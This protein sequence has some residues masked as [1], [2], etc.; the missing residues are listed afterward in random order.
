VSENRR[1]VGS[2]LSGASHA[3]GMADRDS[4]TIDIH[5]GVVN[6]KDIGTAERDNS[7]C[8]VEFP[9]KG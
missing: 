4:S 6:P 5:L 1:R 7:E 2:N 8:L 9:S 3:E